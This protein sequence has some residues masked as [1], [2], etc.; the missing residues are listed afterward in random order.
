METPVSDFVQTGSITIQV[1]LNSNGT[2]HAFN[3]EGM[4]PPEAIGHLIVVTDLIRETQKMA[5]FHA[6]AE[7]R[8]Q[9]EEGEP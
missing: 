4:D 8:R 7:R 6:Q 1:G 3:F 2:A 9:Q 5:W